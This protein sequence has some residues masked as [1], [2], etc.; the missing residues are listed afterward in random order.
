MNFEKEKVVLNQ[1]FAQNPEM[2][3]C[4]DEDRT[5]WLFN[6]SAY[7]LTSNA[8]KEHQQG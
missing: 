4:T 3:W 1:V 6:S 5:E 7:E 8:L 2:F